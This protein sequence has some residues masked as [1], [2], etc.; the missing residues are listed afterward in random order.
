GHARRP[1]RPPRARG[2]PPPGGGARPGTAA[3]S[4]ARPPLA[5]R[6]V[7][8]RVV[9][10][11][12]VPV[13]E[14]P[15]G[16][17][18][19]GVELVVVGSS[20]AAVRVRRD[21]KPV[22]RSGAAG[23]APGAVTPALEHGVVLAAGPVVRALDVRQGRVLAELPAGRAVRAMTVSP[24][25]DVALLDESGDLALHRLASHFAVV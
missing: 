7:R 6:D 13:T 17:L 24:R 2:A 21:G 25:L 9:W 10:Q 8:G 23:V 20:G 3:P 14:R 15:A 22:W 18:R 12:A 19:A 4:G 16:V 11:R 5:C 1:P